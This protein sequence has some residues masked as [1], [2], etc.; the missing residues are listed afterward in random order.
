MADP[1]IDFSREAKR[2]PSDTPEPR[3]ARES[4]ATRRTP[5][6]HDAHEPPTD[7]LGNP[8]QEGRGLSTAMKVLGF[9]AVVTL[10]IILSVALISLTGG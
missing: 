5:R 7:N 9:I 6:A 2:P 10:G 1:N 4:R 8:I 3:D